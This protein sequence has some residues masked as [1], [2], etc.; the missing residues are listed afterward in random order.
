M[1]A[2]DDRLVRHREE[3]VVEGLLED[4]R[5]PA[6]QSVVSQDEPGDALFLIMTG[7]VKVVI[8]GENGR[9]VTLSILRPGDAFG[10]MSLFDGESRSANCMAL[11]RPLLSSSQ[12]RPIASPCCASAASKVCPTA[13][14]VLLRCLPT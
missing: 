13:R 4:R 5:V 8:F 11:K 2:V 1:A 12:A 14:S 7:R 10:E 9:E 3:D 6:G